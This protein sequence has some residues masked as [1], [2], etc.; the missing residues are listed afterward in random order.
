MI[1]LGMTTLLNHFAMLLDLNV[2]DY[3][4]KFSV[5][6]FMETT[7]HKTY[8][9]NTNDPFKVEDLLVILYIDKSFDSIGHVG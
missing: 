1:Y 4:L 6:Y 7:S 9:E 2:K 8:E 5:E 3:L